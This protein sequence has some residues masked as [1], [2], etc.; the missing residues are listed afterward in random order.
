MKRIMLCLGMCLML[1][2]TGCSSSDKEI[3]YDEKKV[4]AH[5]QEIVKLVNE[6]QY[7]E[8][9]ENG[10]EEMKKIKKS[11]KNIINIMSCYIKRQPY[12]SR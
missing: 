6:D 9:L 5:A 1:L 4:V 12:I 10:T 8:I 11:R 3:K 2:A 7:G